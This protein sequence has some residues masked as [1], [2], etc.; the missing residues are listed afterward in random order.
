MLIMSKV[1]H[2]GQ[3]RSSSKARLKIFEIVKLINLKNFSS[4]E[5]KFKLWVINLHAI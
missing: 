5:V 1:T 2:Q 4:V 3:E